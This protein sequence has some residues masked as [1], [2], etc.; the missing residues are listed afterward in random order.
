MKT[1]T[2]GMDMEINRKLGGRR[3]KQEE[4]QGTDRVGNV[5]TIDRE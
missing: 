4:E 5:G 2:S 3:E 1:G